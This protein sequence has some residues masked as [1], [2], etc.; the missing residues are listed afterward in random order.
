MQVYLWTYLLAIVT[1]HRICWLSDNLI[2][3]TRLPGKHIPQ[4]F[5]SIYT[6]CKEVCFN[7]TQH[8]IP[9]RPTYYTFFRLNKLD[10]RYCLVSFKGQ[11]TYNQLKLYIY[12]TGM[13]MPSIFSFKRSIS[14][15]IIIWS[16]EGLCDVNFIIS[17]Y[18]FMS[19]ASLYSADYTH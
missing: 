13:E 7:I 15:Q 10:I 11:Y 3:M 1:S 8:I 9:H 17:P 5:A 16:R 12:P 6:H 14:S 4:T 18:P 2:P 19:A